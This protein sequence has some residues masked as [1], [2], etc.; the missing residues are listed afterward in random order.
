MRRAQDRARSATIKLL[1]QGSQPHIMTNKLCNKLGL[2]RT[3]IG[4]TLSGI[5]QGNQCV[6]YQVTTKVSSRVTDFSTI[7]TCL[8][9]DKIS[10][11]LP[12]QRLQAANIMIFN[13]IELADPYFDKEQP[14]DML[15]GSA[16]FY[17]LLCVGQIELK[18]KEPY[19][20]KTLFGWVVGRSMQVPAQIR[21][22]KLIC[23]KITNSDL[24]SQLE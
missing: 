5:E 13:G 10:D 9:I 22:D 8:V 3:R 1:D 11:N 6:P 2:Q 21:N 14:I 15:I 4:T 12:L 19:F 23:N 17:E 16:L 24:N 7:I 20:Y 18:E